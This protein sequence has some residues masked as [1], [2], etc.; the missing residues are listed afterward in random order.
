MSSSGLI[1]AIRK[2]EQRYPT[3][4]IRNGH[5]YRRSTW[6]ASPTVRRLREMKKEARMHDANR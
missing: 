1:Q 6:I 5:Q 2:S 4:V 3:D